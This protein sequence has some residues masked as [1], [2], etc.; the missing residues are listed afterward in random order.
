MNKT[1]N[2]IALISVVL[3]TS[4]GT[5]SM[6]PIQPDSKTKIINVENNNKQ[7][8]FIKANN[9]MAETFNDAK[10]VIQFTDKESGVVTGRYLMKSIITSTTTRENVYAIIKIQV[11]DNVA[12]I[13]IKPNSY[14][15]SYNSFAGGESFPIEKANSSMELLMASF[16]VAIKAKKDSF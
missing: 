7:D 10:S 4:C 9:W 11:K 6:V 2:L 3:I 5:L 1:K 15:N 8:L 14:V 13:E 12:K 16:E